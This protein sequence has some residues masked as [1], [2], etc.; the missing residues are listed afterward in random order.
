MNN[1]CSV[2]DI[3]RMITQAK[4]TSDKRLLSKIYKELLKL[5]NKNN[6]L[7]KTWAKDLNRHLTKEDIQRVNKHMKMFHSECHQGNAN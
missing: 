7:I 6:N 2:K 3:K 4:D 5:K 1:F